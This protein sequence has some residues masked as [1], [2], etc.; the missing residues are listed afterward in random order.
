MN[1]KTINLKPTTYQKLL[2]YKHMDRTFDEVIDEMMD[3]VDPMEMY[4]KA[5][6]EHRERLKAMKE[7]EYVTL[8]EL[9]KN[10]KVS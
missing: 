1:Y 4:E 3:E 2:R 7:G 10:L 9:K 8:D 6:G 5:L